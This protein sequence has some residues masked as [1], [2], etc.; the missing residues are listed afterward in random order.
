MCTKRER[1][2]AGRRQVREDL[3]EEGTSEPSCEGCTSISRWKQEFTER[4]F[5][6]EGTACTE[7]GN[8]MM[9]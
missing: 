9:R 6:A 8:S 7:A 3:T 2:R 1:H 5:Q 4:V